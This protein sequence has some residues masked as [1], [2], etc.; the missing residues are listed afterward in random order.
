MFCQNCGAQVPDGSPFCPNCGTPQA[1]TQ[2]PQQPA[3][4]QQITPVHVPVQVP[5]YQM[6]V[7]AAPKKKKKKWPWFLGGGIL[8]A[9]GV[10]VLLILLLGSSGPQKTAE[11]YMEAVAARDIKGMMENAAFDVLNYGFDCSSKQE[12]VD[13]INDRFD[14]SFTK[15]DDAAEYYKNWSNHR[16]GEGKLSMTKLSE[17]EF[18]TWEI[19]EFFEERSNEDDE[20]NQTYR[21][22]RRSAVDEMIEY[23]FRATYTDEETSERMTLTVWVVKIDG[24]WGVIDWDD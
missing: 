2:I 8:L 22:V 5:A 1:V 20:G 17:K 11:N 23:E 9:A 7:T 18:S 14:T 24:D 10:A 13:Y 21:G 6:P 4:P 16:H 3:Q 12:F 15:F 19:D